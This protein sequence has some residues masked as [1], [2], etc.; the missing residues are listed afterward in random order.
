MPSAP[1]ESR[2]RAVISSKPL[3]VPCVLSDSAT[4]SGIT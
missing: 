2:T 4:G 1:S 3:M